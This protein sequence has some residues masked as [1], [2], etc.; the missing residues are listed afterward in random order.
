MSQI[1][2]QVSSGVPRGLH[3]GP[4]L[5][6]L[7]INDISNVFAD[8]SFLVFADDLKLFRTVDC[9]DDTLLLQG[10]LDSFA[11]WCRCNDLAISKDKCK[12]TR[13]SRNMSS[14]CITVLYVNCNNLM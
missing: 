1:T 3:L 9:L 2:V 6:L 5:F 14:L 10:D 12:V 11:S 13:F 8:S 7:Y 4:V